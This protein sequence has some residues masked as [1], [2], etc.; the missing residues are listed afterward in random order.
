L[1]SG[2]STVDKAPFSPYPSPVA[3]NRKPRLAPGFFE[4]G[5]SSASMR[6]RGIR[7]SGW[8]TD[9]ELRLRVTASPC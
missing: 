5:R 4:A 1:R 2:I 7:V 8:S 6:T 3:R 9:A